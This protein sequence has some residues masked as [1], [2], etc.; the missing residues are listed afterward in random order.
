M[1]LILRINRNKHR[2]KHRNRKSNAVFDSTQ[3]KLEIFLKVFLF[4]FDRIMGAG[5]SSINRDNNK[6][7]VPNVFWEEEDNEDTLTDDSDNEEDDY[8]NYYYNHY[9]SSYQRPATNRK[10]IF[11]FSDLLSKSE[12]ICHTKPNI[13]PVFVRYLFSGNW[14]LD[15]LRSSSTSFSKSVQGKCLEENTPHNETDSH[16]TFSFLQEHSSKDVDT[17]LLLT[18]AVAL[19]VFGRS[20][21]FLH[22]SEHQWSEDSVRSV[23]WQDYTCFGRAQIKQQYRTGESHGSP[24][25]LCCWRTI[26]LLDALYVH[27]VMKH[28]QTSI[29]EYLQRVDIRNL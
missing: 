24:Q 3:I 10:P 26:A 13:C 6:F 15:L 19:Q 22:L 9:R 7:S 5:S 21:L 17:V 25:H 27:L 4:D 18:L 20:E 28:S 11:Q 12:Y 2:L 29:Y 14:I 8:D 23:Q 16:P 1:Y